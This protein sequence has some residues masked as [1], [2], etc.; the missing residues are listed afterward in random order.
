MA[1]SNSNRRSFIKMTATAMVVAPSV[2]TYRNALAQNAEKLTE[3]DPLAMALGYK[4]KT[5]D[6]DAVKYP[7][8]TKEQVC[9]ACILYQGT[10]PEWGGCGAFANK[11]V[12]GQGWCQVYAA[13][14]S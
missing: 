11:L 14:P 5:T 1:S 3:D 4:E 2:I 13:K 8:H 7:T 6:V 12:A 9:I 10:D